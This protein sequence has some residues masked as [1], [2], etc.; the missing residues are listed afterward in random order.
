MEHDK[1]IQ[2]SKNTV[3]NSSINAGGNIHIGDIINI[4]QAVSESTTPKSSFNADQAGA[5]RKLIGNNK[6]KQALEQLLQH[7][8]GQEEDIYM[9]VVQLSQQWNKLQRQETMGILSS[10]E[11]NVTSN[12]IVY[13]LLDV[14]NQLE[15][16]G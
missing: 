12:K 5:I 2:D 7:T 14:V 4:Q 3:N 8:N 13:G 16:Q 11:A 15:Q 6:I 1:P 10:S 9:Q